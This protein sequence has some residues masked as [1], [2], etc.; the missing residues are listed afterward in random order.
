[1]E[2]RSWLAAPALA[3]G[4]TTAKAERPN[5]VVLMMDDFGIGHFAPMAARM[6]AADFHP[7]YAQWLKAKGVP[8][9]AE[10]ALDCAQRAM[11]NLMEMAR[12]GVLFTNHHATSN[13]CAPSRAGLLTGR[14]Q[15]QFG[16]Y[17]NS[18]TEA[19]G[20]PAGT[21]LAQHFQAAGYATGFVG[22]WHVGR[23]DEGLR[24]EVLRGISPAEAKSYEAQVRATGYLGA[25]VREHHPLEHGFD[26][27]Y[28]YNRWECPFYN[29]EHIWENHTFTGKQA[30]YNTELFAEK[31]IAFLGKA[32]REQKPFYLHIAPHA[33]HGPLQPKAPERHFAKFPSRAYNLTNFYAHVHAVDE[34]VGQ[35]RAAMTEAEWNNTLFAFC[36]DNGAPLGLDTVLPG[37]GALR[38]HKGTFYLGGVRVPLL[39]HWPQG[40][41]TKAGSVAAMTSN[42]DIL[43]T[44]MAAAGLKTP[45]G[46]E[47]RSL[48]PVARGEAK[49]VHENLLWAGI[50]ARA[51]GFTRETTI[52]DFNQRREESPGAWL[53]TDGTYALRYVTATP[54]GLFRD[55]PEG[56]AAH[57]EL[58]DLREDPGEARNLAAQLPEVVAKLAKVYRDRAKSLAPPAKWR[59]D[60]WE[61]M[62]QKN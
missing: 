19:A 12:R 43:P 14:L 62:N 5:I 46:V 4:Q 56:E 22:K 23:R 60:R 18:D 55:L 31:S 32:L 48:L 11:P 3:L 37:N 40:L 34:L 36:S 35:V 24:A 61:E 54:K 52:G 39:L 45:V 30:R 41:G 33:V 42:M 53:V 8:Y 59:R 49:T 57:Y 15:N 7:E 20:T 29:S 47:G 16:H 9:S 10:Q 26:Y 25:V 21:I 6:K 28:G 51:W 50:H 2:R 58:H 27:Y 38:G 13:L 1:M 17:Q 44:A